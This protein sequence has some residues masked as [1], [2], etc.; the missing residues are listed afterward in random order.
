MPTL[1]LVVAGTAAAVFLAL[2]RCSEL[3]KAVLE[4]RLAEVAQAY[5]RLEKA[6][7]KAGRELARLTDRDEHGRFVRRE[8]TE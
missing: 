1:L 5:D 2:W 6:H 8:N 4:E 3:E 7:A